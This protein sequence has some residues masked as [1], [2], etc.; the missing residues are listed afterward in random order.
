MAYR[1]LV[2][3]RIQEAMAAGHFSNL[4]GEGQRQRYDDAESLAGEQWLGHKMLKDANLL[5]EWLMLARDIERALEQL[6]SLD[7]SHAELTD[8]A[9]ET[10]RWESTLPAISRLRAKYEEQARAVRRMQDRFNHDAP[11]IRLE[12]PAIWVEHHLDRLD[13]RLSCPLRWR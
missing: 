3:S 7:R 9:R 5:P 12:R 8:S 10:G 4:R 13:C 6:A 11:S 2:E 1:D